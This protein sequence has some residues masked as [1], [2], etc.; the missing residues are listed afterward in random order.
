MR[1]VGARVLRFDGPMGRGWWW[2]LAPQNKKRRARLTALGSKGSESSEGCGIAFGDE[3]KASV[4]CFPAE[5]VILSE[6]KNLGKRR[7]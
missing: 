4:T 2:R 6:A 7:Q 3:Y 1:P 5:Q